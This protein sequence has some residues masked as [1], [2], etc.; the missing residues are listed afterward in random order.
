M[1]TDREA[2]A[3]IGTI[4][5]SQDTILSLCKHQHIEGMLATMKLTTR[6]DRDYIGNEALSCSSG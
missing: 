3:V 4:N 1:P 6:C 2:C 5:A